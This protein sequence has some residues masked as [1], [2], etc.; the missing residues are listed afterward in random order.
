MFLRAARRGCRAGEG[1]C[2]NLAP[3][4]G[5]RRSDIDHLQRR[6][7]SAGFGNVFGEA[8]RILASIGNADWHKRSAGLTCLF[9]VIPASPA[10]ASLLFA[11]GEAARLLLCGA[12]NLTRRQQSH[13]RARHGAART[14][15]A[16]FAWVWSPALVLNCRSRVCMHHIALIGV[17]EVS[18]RTPDD[19]S[20]H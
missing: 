10:P 7:P 11:G 6:T 18:D 1:H 12:A 19:R 15:L 8:S 14:R 2:G 5:K 3:S 20:G 4:I 13:E 17:A 9:G 16:I